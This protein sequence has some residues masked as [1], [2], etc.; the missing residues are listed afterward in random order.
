MAE[1]LG[2]DK[3]VLIFSPNNRQFLGR[4]SV[5]LSEVREVPMIMLTRNYGI[6]QLRKP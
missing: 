1:I 2:I 4:K 3:L 5:K 6:L